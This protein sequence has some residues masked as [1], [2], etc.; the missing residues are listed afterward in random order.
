MTVHNDNDQMH[1]HSAGYSKMR[2]T[3]IMATK[4]V[5]EHLCCA[6]QTTF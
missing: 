1:I 4:D 2:N 5:P 3:A 6:W